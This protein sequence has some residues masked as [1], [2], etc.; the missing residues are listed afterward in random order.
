VKTRLVIAALLLVALVWPLALPT[1]LLAS[2][3][4]ETQW[5]KTFGGT[6][7][8]EGNSVQ[9]TSDGGYIIASTTNSSGAGSYD[10]YLIKTD[11][12]GNM[13][14]SNTFGGAG[15][16]WGNS[17]Q[18]TSDGG[19]IITGWTDSFG[20]G[21][22]DVYLIK[23]DSSGNITWS[24]TLGGVGSDGANSIQPTKDGG[25]IIAGSTSSFVAG[26]YYD[27]YLI[28]TDSSG[29]ITWSKT[30][31]GASGDGASSMQP[32]KDGGYII[33]GE[34]WSIG[35]GM[36]D[37]WLI[38]VAALLPGDATG[39][40]AVDARDITKVER[41]IAHLDPPTP[42]AD[43]NQDGLV[44]ARDITQVEIIIIAALGQPKSV[45]N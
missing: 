33:V 16:D 10:V 34:T 9:Q 20:A 42:G 36:A 12:N 43:A 6:N 37:V 22:A 1:P 39:D 19:Y 3:P 25:Y 38:K 32:T 40:G 2:E 5:T 29:N 28:K 27:V 21:F 30:L 8:E 11:S 31:G 45:G 7:Y 18:P 35:A 15:W 44:D 23:T 41:I 26:D 13:V 17:V 24:K 14:W 4:P